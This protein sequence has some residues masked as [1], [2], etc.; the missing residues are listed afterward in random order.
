MRHFRINPRDLLGREESPALR[1]AFITIL[2]RVDRLNLAAEELPWLVRS[3]R[4]RAETM[5]ICRLSVR[6]AERLVKGDPLATRVALT[7]TDGAFSLIRALGALMW[8]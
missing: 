5:F 2:D 1:R 4:L 8:R 6:L 7:K 3:R